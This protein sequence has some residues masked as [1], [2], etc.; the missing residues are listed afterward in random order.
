MRDR[1]GIPVLPIGGRL[2][3]YLIWSAVRQAYSRTATVQATLDARR[4]AM[5]LSP[6][7]KA[8][9]LRALSFDLDTLAEAVELPSTSIA[10]AE[11]LIAEGERIAGAIRTLFRGR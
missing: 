11:L 4:P 8:A 1:R 6:S 7:E 9:R 10:R 3:P 5:G 2:F